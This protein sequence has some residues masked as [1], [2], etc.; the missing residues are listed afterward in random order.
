MS[1]LEAKIN[2]N[3]AIIEALISQIRVVENAGVCN[4]VF[5]FINVVL[6]DSEPIEGLPYVQQEI[7]LSPRA[8][9]EE[10]VQKI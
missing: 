7:L 10:K 4:S 6:D 9:K 5:N 2:S 8:F 1:R 3:V